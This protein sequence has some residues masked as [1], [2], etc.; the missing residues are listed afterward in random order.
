MGA[1]L[2]LYPKARIDMLIP[3]L[4]FGPFFRIPAYVFLLYWI[5][6]QLFNGSMSLGHVGG[7]G[8]AWW[9]HVGGF[10]TGFL[11]CTLLTPPQDHPDTYRS[12]SGRV[13]YA[14]R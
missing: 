6:L 8:V 3:P 4:V 7:G 5:V 10:A 11:L 9:A 13:R 1:Y 14:R 2:R 12:P